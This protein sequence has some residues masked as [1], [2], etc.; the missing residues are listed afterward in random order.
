MRINWF[1]VQLCVHVYVEF[2]LFNIKLKILMLNLL[3]KNW[4]KLYQVCLTLRILF[5]DE[6]TLTNF[7]PLLILHFYCLSF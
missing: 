6:E 1:I 4:H 5:V 7:S 2:C 3:C